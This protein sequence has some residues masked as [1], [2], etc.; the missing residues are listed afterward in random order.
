MPLRVPLLVLT[1]VA[2]LAND[3]PRLRQLGYNQTPLS[4]LLMKRD[5]ISDIKLTPY[6]PELDA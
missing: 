5:F 1:I 3:L 6:V 4:I 2:V